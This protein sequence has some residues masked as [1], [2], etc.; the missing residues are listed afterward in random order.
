MFNRSHY[1]WCLLHQFYF[2]EPSGFRPKCT[3]KQ[4]NPKLFYIDPL[5][6]IVVENLSVLGYVVTHFGISN[7][8]KISFWT[9]VKTDDRLIDHFLQ[10]VPYSLTPF[11]SEISLPPTWLGTRVMVMWLLI[12]CQSEVVLENKWVIT[13]KRLVGKR[14]YCARYSSVPCQCFIWGSN[15][16]RLRQLL[17]HQQQSLLW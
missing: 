1:L 11:P 2:F 15:P 13:V 12:S 9:F 17:E 7:F 16:I 8:L 3:S 14:H 5:A 4:N 10:S 6:F